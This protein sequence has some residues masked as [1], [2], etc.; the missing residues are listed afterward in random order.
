[1]KLRLA[2]NLVNPEFRLLVRAKG[3]QDEWFCILTWP[4]KKNPG[5]GGGVGWFGCLEM[6]VLRMDLFYFF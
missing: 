4:Q 1:V 5:G 2:P 6:G 3:Y